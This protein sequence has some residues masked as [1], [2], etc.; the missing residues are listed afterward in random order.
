MFEL[1][2]TI[3]CIEP[4]HLSLAESSPWHRRHRAPVNLATALAGAASASVASV[5]SAQARG[6]VDR[7]AG[8][9][10]QRAMENGQ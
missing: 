4:S 9:W 7:A 1:D 2:L 8:H 3:N 6:R 5:A 10:L